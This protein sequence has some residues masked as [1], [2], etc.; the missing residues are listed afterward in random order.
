[1][2][3]RHAL[4][5][6]GP[7]T[8]LSVALAGGTLAGGA[9]LIPRSEPAVYRFTLHAPE[10]DR[11]IWISAWNDG[12]VYLSHD[13]SDGKKIVLTRTADEH[14]GCRWKGTETLTPLGAHA[15]LYEYEDEMLACEED[16]EPFRV[17]PRRGVVT[18]EKIEGAG[19]MRLTKLDD[20][21][22]PG[23]LWNEADDDELDLTIQIEAA[24]DE[25]VDRA[26]D[27]CGCDAD[28]DDDGEMDQVVLQDPRRDVE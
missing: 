14:D 17:T 26:D 23:D 27:D 15:Y 25:A 18:V 24:I 12:D 7:R 16:A 22:A 6:L 5:A 3:L 2:M 4:T 20:T 8:L 1:M 19:D 13:G 9:L 10:R 11:T 28:D 21:Q